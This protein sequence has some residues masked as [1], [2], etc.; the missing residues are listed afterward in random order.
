MQKYQVMWSRNGVQ[1]IKDFTSKKAALARI[2]ELKKDPNNKVEDLWDTR[3]NP[4]TSL[5]TL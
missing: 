2:R 4:L 5:F 3:D 1:H